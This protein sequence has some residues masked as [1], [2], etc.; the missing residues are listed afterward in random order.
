MQLGGQDFHSKT[1]LI[2]QDDTDYVIY[3]T[4]HEHAVL[5]TAHRLHDQI[6]LRR[7]ENTGRRRQPVGVHSYL[8]AQ[9]HLNTSWRTRLQKNYTNDTGLM[10]TWYRHEKLNMILHEKDT[11]RLHIPRTI[12][13]TFHTCAAKSFITS[14][15]KIRRQR[16]F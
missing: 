16:P 8:P 7:C 10:K 6:I 13:H 9:T 12:I 5:F 14:S 11:L 3:K 1:K 2:Y 15:T 4:E